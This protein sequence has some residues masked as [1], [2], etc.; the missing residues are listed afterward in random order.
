MKKKMNEILEDKTSSST[1]QVELRVG[2]LRIHGMGGSSA[3]LNW[4][5]RQGLIEKVSEIS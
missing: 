1:I 5:E 3:V 4:G 2:W